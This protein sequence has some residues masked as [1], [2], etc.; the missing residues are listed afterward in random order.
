MG[1]PVA[2]AGMTSWPHRGLKN[3]P[4]QSARKNALP[5][6]L[7]FG[8]H[9]L[10]YSLFGLRDICYRHPLGGGTAAQKERPC[11][12]RQTAVHWAKNALGAPNARYVG[13]VPPAHTV[14]RASG[15]LFAEEIH[16]IRDWP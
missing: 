7:E 8:T 10:T 11:G 12:Y 3:A 9:L 6:H 15:A 16:D 2:L 13:P 5:H 14:V 4:L 1:S